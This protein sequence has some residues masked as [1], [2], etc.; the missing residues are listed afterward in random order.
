MSEQSWSCGGFF[1]LTVSGRPLSGLA[2]MLGVHAEQPGP[3]LSCICFCTDTA[4]GSN[5]LLLKSLVQSSSKC[6]HAV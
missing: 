4:Q 1:M 5:T 2:C 6:V 3:P